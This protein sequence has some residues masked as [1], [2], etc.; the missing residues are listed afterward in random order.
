MEESFSG[1]LT[2]K[3][4][5]SLRLRPKIEKSRSINTKNSLRDYRMDEDK[6]VDKKEK[7]SVTITL[8]WVL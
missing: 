7:R 4:V 8:N 1:G 3:L 6:G 5:I 2:S